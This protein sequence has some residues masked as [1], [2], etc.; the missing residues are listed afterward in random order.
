MALIPDYGDPKLPGVRAKY[1]FLEAYVSIAGNVLIFVFQ[2]TFGLLINSIALMASAIHTLSDVGSSAIVWFGFREARKEADPEHPYGHG[3][4]EHVATL[5]IAVLLF[6]VGVEFVIDSISR[7]LGE[8]GVVVNTYLVPVSILMIASFVGKELMA[9][10]SI[11][12]GK[13]IDSQTLI[14]DA[15]HHRTDGMGALLVLV[16]VVGACF[17]YPW[18]DPLFGIAIALL[19]FYAGYEFARGAAD[20]LVGKAPEADFTEAIKTSAESVQGVL[21]THDVEVHDYGQEKRVSLHVGVSA[22][23][24][25]KKAHDIADRV[26]DS[27]YRGTGARVVAHV[28]IQEDP[29]EPGEVRKDI[30]G[31]LSPR[32]EVVSFHITDIRDDGETRRLELHVLVKSGTTVEVTHELDHTL[33]EVLAKHC[34]GLDVSLH[35]EPCTSDCEECGQTCDVRDERG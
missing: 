3:R 23:I 18:L 13:R 19:I 8:P 26:E 33:R 28:C 2:I 14:A 16:G 22:G 34:S 15:W 7:L 29:M 9:R 5:V 10:F 27:V 1:G 12:L 35:I 11:S 17:G 25:A 31:I 32:G 21:G 30:E 20:T 6:M 24:S 4:V